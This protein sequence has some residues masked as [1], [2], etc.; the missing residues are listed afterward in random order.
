M[1]KYIQA[2]HFGH[3]L[4]AIMQLEDNFMAEGWEYHTSSYHNICFL[5]VVS[6]LDLPEQYIGV[7]TTVG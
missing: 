3:I 1:F 5:G 2:V 7:N 6:S 4:F